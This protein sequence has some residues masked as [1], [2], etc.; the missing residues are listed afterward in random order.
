MGAALCLVACRSYSSSP[1]TVTIVA[2]NDMHGVVWPVKAVWRGEA[3]PPLAGG[4]SAL[5]H[6][7]TRIRNEKKNVLLL[8]AGDFFQG[9]PEGN[10]SLGEIPLIVMNYLGYD[11]LTLGNHDFDFGVEPVISLARSATFSF[12]AA[13]LRII[14][15]VLSPF[16]RDYAIFDVAGVRVLVI[17]VTTPGLVQYSAPGLENYLLAE[18][19]E[20]AVRR[21][22]E[23]TAGGYDVCVVLSHIGD[24]RDRELAAAV[25]GIDIIVGG[26][27]HTG[28]EEPIKV[29]STLIVQ[30]H[31]RNTTAAVLTFDCR[32]RT[33]GVTGASYQLLELEYD[34]LRRDPAV[35]LLLEYLTASV[36]EAVDIEI[37]WAVEGLARGRELESSPLGSFIA[38]VI[39]Q[40]A[41]ADFA[42]HNRAGIRADLPS[43]PV[44]KRDI[45]EVSPFENTIVVMDMTGAEI[46]DLLGYIFRRDYYAYDFSEGISVTVDASAQPDERVAEVL[47]RNEP[48]NNA[49]VYRVA[50]N[51][52]IA[53]AIARHRGPDDPVRIADTGVLLRDAIAGAVS[54]RDEFTYS[55][56]PRVKAI[57]FE[58][59]R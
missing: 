28:I 47:V 49:R 55:F 38:D 10:M 25:D 46:M 31:G 20:D 37:G 23:E 57:E 32:P 41:G 3:D 26:H 48:V 58:F 7:V 21:V 19:E 42:L 54:A 27:S 30:G 39:S 53:E 56:S 15:P 18:K 8:D 22:I 2:T 44:T 11:A 50:T 34:E 45:L 52:F 29:N 24:Q 12:L 51:S 14:D 9:T 36:R 4:F 40:T 6:L 43:G 13:N 1:V 35:E 33:R 5:S 16:F 59:S 17:G